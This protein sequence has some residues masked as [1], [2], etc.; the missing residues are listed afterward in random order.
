[1]D[2][3]VKAD[4]A[5]LQAATD[6]FTSHLDPI[7]SINDTNLVASITFEPLPVSLI[8]AAIAKSGNVFGLDPSGGPLV[9]I[10]LVVSWT[11]KADDDKIIQ[12]FKGVLQKIKADAIQRGQA[13]DFELMSTA[14]H[15]Q[16]PIASYGADIK[17]RMQAVSRK[18]DPN[19]LLRKGLQGG[20]K[21]FP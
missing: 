1:M 5:T 12:H 9:S 6:L 18:Y 2:T 16:D 14:F 7:K 20:F 8:Q 10:S 13:V 3:T 15:F 4:T 11:R 19:G 17:R 21:L